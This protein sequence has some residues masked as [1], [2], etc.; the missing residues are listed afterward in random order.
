MAGWR[1][2]STHRSIVEFRSV[3]F[4]GKKMDWMYVSE[5]GKLFRR[6]VKVK[7][8]TAGMPVKLLKPPL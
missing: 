2:C 5:G 6:P 1:R 3:V 8:V 4:A 7:G